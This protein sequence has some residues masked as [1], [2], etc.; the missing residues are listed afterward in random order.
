MQTG[1]QTYTQRLKMRGGA[2]S[3]NGACSNNGASQDGIN[4]NSCSESNKKTSTQDKMKTIIQ[5]H[6]NI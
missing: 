6:L 4:K 2:S 1:S 3:N 5:L